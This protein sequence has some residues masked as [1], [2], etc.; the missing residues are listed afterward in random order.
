MPRTLLL[1]DPISLKQIGPVNFIYG[2]DNYDDGD[3]ELPTDI[4][5]HQILYATNLIQLE[6]LNQQLQT[7]LID[8]SNNI[9]Q[10]SDNIMI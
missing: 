3:D 4:N 9:Q 7:L 6:A 1:K 8:T 10:P 5:N 2:D